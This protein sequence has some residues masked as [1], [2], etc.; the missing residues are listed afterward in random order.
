MDLGAGAAEIPQFRLLEVELLLRD[1]VLAIG[2]AAIL[3]QLAADRAFLQ[4][5]D[6]EQLLDDFE[7]ALVVQR[8]G[9]DESDAGLILL[10]LDG[11]GLERRGVERLE[12]VL[13]EPDVDIRGG[14]EGDEVGLVLR[15]ARSEFL[16]IAVAQCLQHFARRHDVAGKG[17]TPSASQAPSLSVLR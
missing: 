7:L 4:Q 16:V 12:H 13:E 8:L 6:A 9:G 17:V 2:V 14:V 1:Q 15:H 3:E 10:V 5:P 11:V